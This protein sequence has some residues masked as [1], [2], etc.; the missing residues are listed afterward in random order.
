[1]ISHRS[2]NSG[3][4]PFSTSG[5]KQTETLQRCSRPNSWRS[6]APGGES[7]GRKT[8]SSRLN[9]TFRRHAP[10]LDSNSRPP[11]IT[12]HSYGPRVPNRTMSCQLTTV[13]LVEFQIGLASSLRG[14]ENPPEGKPKSG[15]PSVALHRAGVPGLADRS[16][17][18][19]AFRVGPAAELVDTV[20]TRR[21]RLGWSRRPYCAG[22]RL[23]ECTSP[24]GKTRGLSDGA[25]SY[26]TP[27]AG[28]HLGEGITAGL[29]SLLSPAVRDSKGHLVQGFLLEEGSRTK[30]GRRDVAAGEQLEANL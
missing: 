24:Q 26:S 6:C 21:L 7:G 22:R 5:G 30:H 12:R 25:G 14:N 4:T 10:S 20:E 3:R 18:Q 11:R 17:R 28:V 1:V 27:H 2:F 19:P 15:S 13:L 9:K 8:G 16:S 29:R 23:F